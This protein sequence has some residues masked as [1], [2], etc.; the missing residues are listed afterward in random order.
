MKKWVETL[1]V[2][3]C[4]VCLISG[5]ASANHTTF[6]INGTMTLSFSGMPYGTDPFVHLSIS[7]FGELGI[8]TE[9]CCNCLSSDH[10][11]DDLLWASVSLGLILQQNTDIDTDA[12]TIALYRDMTISDGSMNALTETA[13]TTTQVN[14]SSNYGNLTQLVV[15]DGIACNVFSW[16][17][18]KGVFTVREQD[19]WPVPK[20]VLIITGVKIENGVASV[21]VKNC[22]N[23]AAV[24]NNATITAGLSYWDGWVPEGRF[25]NDTSQGTWFW[26]SNYNVV[27]QPGQTAIFSFRLPPIPDGAVKNFHDRW[28][29]WWYGNKDLEPDKDYV[30]FIIRITGKEVYFFVPFTPNI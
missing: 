16:L 13:T 1:L 18:L 20:V 23:V 19:N 26:Q 6:Y 28:L 21:A 30:G 7:G 27:I 2:A 8:K 22:G 10:P 15:T 17:Y 25:Y 11:L 9:V 5:I 24:D 12:Q 14:F 3:S 29:T 4:L